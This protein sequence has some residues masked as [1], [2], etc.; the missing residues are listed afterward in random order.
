MYRVQGKLLDNPGHDISE[1]YKILANVRF[2]TSK[3]DLDIYYIK[4]S[5]QFASQVAEQLKTEDLREFPNF[6]NHQNRV[7]IKASELSSDQK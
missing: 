2:A 7:D 3:T 1:L 4:L 6:Q 5:I